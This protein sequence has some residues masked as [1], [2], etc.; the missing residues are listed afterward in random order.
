MDC[1]DET[2]YRAVGFARSLLVCELPDGGLKLL[3]GQLRRELVPDMEVDV[4]VLDVTE[5]EARKLPLNI[6]PLAA[7]R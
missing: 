4:E 1:S 5:D 7:W 6:D 2:I 3:G